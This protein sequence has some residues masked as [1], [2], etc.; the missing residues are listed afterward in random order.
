MKT[1]R[2]LLFDTGYILNAMGWPQLGLDS[3]EISQVMDV[4]AFIIKSI[5]LPTQEIYIYFSIK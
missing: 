2:Y 5:N 1:T 3:L 4:K